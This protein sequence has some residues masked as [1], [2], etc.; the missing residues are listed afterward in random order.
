MQKLFNRADTKTAKKTLAI[1]REEILKDKKSFIIYTT[2]I[3][4]NR[5]LYLVMLPLIFSLVIQSL[6][7]QPT[8][9]Q[10]PVFL[11]VIGAVIS[12]V[13]LLFA[14]IGDRKSTRLNSSHIQKSRMPSSA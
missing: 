6:I 7:L 11:L 4:I 12:I 3:P 13:A 9:W 8:N 1:F 14:D 2:L 10:Y 5:L